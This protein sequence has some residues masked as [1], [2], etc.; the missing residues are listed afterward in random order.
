MRLALFI[1]A[2]Y[3]E[4]TINPAPAFTLPCLWFRAVKVNDEIGTDRFQD[5]RFHT[6]G[7][8]LPTFTNSQLEMAATELSNLQLKFSAERRIGPIVQG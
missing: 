4:G 3:N 5:N 2:A 7:N 1:R 8:Y 6:D